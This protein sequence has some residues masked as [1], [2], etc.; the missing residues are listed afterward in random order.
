MPTL[1]KSFLILLL[2]TGFAI[3]G[4][5]GRAASARK[6]T[7][8]DQS[9]ST[10]GP[11]ET[12]APAVACAD[13]PK[14]V[15]PPPRRLAPIPRLRRAKKG[16]YDDK[17]SEKSAKELALPIVSQLG[18]KPVC[19]PN[20]VPVIK[21]RP[22]KVEKGNPLFAADP[23]AEYLKYEGRA[24]AEFFLRHI[25][26]FEEVYKRPHPEGENSPPPP[27]PPAPPC[28]GVAWFGSCYYYGSAAFATAADGGG[29]TNSIEKPA[30][31]NTGGE[32]HT[33]DE[34]A[35]QGGASNGNIIEMGWFVDSEM[36][37]NVNP[38]IFV[39]HWI[40]GAETCYDTCGWQQ[41]SS[42]YHPGMDLGSAVGK[43]VYI[44]YVLYQGNWWGWFDNQW[45]GYFPGSE[46]NGQYT[47]T[48]LI[49]W[50][51]EVASA[52][53]IPPKTQ[54]GNGQ[55]PS[56]T[57]AGD[58]ATLCDVDAKAWVCWYRDQQSLSRTV[59][60]YY[61]ITRVAF[62]ETRYGGPGQ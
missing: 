28:D 4:W 36:E 52:N 60:K 3:L 54:M 56:S 46:W 58:M 42:T 1:R 31:V 11:Q 33:L 62:G 37:G 2:A 19:P 8:G 48:S 24:R 41:W 45:M 55:F 26:R 9:A 34:I 32:G 57:N 21:A 51:G 5:I 22:R 39:Y 27:P 29:M 17:E 47:K 30:Y 16:D 53:G 15:R 43:K 10:A 6:A 35:L 23:N 44:G 49:Q 61:D 20:Q 18:F 40:N 38:H 7:P 12:A 14:G 25:R 59:P 50:F 13:R